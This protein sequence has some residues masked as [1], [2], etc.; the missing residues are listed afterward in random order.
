M[1]EKYLP[2]KYLIGQVLLDKNAAVQTVINKTLDVGSQSV[3]RTFPFEVLAGPHKLDVVARENGCEFRFN[4][5]N[6]YWNS[7][8][9]TEHRRILSK[10]QDGEAICDVMAGVGPFAVPAGRRRIFV[11]ANDLNPEA[12]RAL[13]DNIARNKVSEFVRPYC[14]D[15]RAFI[16]EATKGLTQVRRSVPFEPKI[17]APRF[18]ANFS[19]TPAT[20]SAKRIDH[21]PPAFDH[22]VMNLPATAVEMLDA[23]KG[24]YHGREKDFAPC[25]E[26]RLPLLHVYLFQATGSNYSDEQEAQ[27]ICERVSKYIGAPVKG[28]DPE[29]E[30]DLFYVRLVSPRKK[31]Y[32]ASFRLPPAVAFATP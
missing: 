14:Q 31:M 7:R 11:H 28:T 30:L 32:C 8:L 1:R 29:I 23:F 17:K 25:T 27:E 19:H 15:G 21:E 5:G 20:A 10:F 13:Q 3:F 2:Y 24:I 16:R 26:R 22:Y 6:V 12:Y 9:E 18:S 4:F